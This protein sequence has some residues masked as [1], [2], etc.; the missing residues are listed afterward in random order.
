[1][2]GYVIKNIRMS[3]GL[4]QRD[5]AKE[6]NVSQQLISF[7]EGEK[8]PISKRLEQ[9]IIYRFNVKPEEIEAIRNL[10]MLRS[11]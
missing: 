6:L 5:F 8:V 1:M 2:E 4:S 3:L 10:K 9:R 7:V 11:K